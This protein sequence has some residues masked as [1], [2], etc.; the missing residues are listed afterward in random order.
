M[1]NQLFPLPFKTHLIFGIICIVFF[2]FQYYRLKYRYE[3]YMAAAVSLTFL[4]YVSDSDVLF[5]AIGISE[6][7]L[8]L[9]A[10][11]SSQRIWAR[12]RREE[13]AEKAAAALNEE[14][15]R[16]ATAEDSDEG[17]DEE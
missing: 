7:V 15:S 16:E 4:L 3:L 9:L 10:F 8:L 5:A 14:L 1:G 6:A 2:L 17:T 12:Q 13:K 11:F